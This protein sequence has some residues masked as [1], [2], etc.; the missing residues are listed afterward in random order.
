M[1]GRDFFVLIKEDRYR[2]TFSSSLSDN[3]SI[4]FLTFFF[5]NH[6]IRNQMTSVIYLRMWKIRKFTELCMRWLTTCSRGSIQLRR[7]VALRSWALIIAAISAAMAGIPV[8]VLYQNQS[9]NTVFF[10]KTQPTR[11][12]NFQYSSP[13]IKYTRS[14]PCLVTVRDPS[15][16]A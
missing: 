2:Y 1:F 12:S 16:D 5:R 8:P 10:G 9:L 13:Y 3:R 6:R 7:L 4:S 15:P 11:F 14:F